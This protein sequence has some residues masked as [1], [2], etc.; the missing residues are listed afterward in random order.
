MRIDASDVRES[1][2]FHG[3]LQTGAEGAL[4]TSG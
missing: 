2:V 4:Q 1:R 3:G